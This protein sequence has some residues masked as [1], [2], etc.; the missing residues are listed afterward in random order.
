MS[1]VDFD[2]HFVSLGPQIKTKTKSPKNWA[3]QIY[4]TKT[5]QIWTKIEMANSN[6][7]MNVKFIE[8]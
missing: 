6:Y 7:S 8:N 5:W 1:S 2:F 3:F 4:T